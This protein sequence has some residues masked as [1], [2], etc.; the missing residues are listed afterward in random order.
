[1]VPAQK[2]IGKQ[3]LMGI[4][5]FIVV[6]VLKYYSVIHFSLYIYGII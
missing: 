2:L 5:S 3:L 6:K 1:M 4:E